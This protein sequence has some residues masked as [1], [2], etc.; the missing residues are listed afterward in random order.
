MLW[1]ELKLLLK[2]FEQYLCRFV[3]LVESE[4]RNVVIAVTFKRPLRRRTFENFD[5]V[6]FE[7]RAETVW[8]IELDFLKTGYHPSGI[9]YFGKMSGSPPKKDVP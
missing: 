7:N 8:Q 2:I 4:T 6:K 9:H 3:A 1:I 5:F